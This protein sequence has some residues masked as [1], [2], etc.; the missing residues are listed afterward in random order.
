[1]EGAACER[2]GAAEGERRGGRNLHRGSGT[3]GGLSGTARPDGREVRAGWVEW[4]SG[5][6]A[7][8]DGRPWAGSEWRVGVRWASGRAGEGERLPDRVGRDRGGAEPAGRGEG[9]R[10]GVAG[11]PRRGRAAG[12]LPGVKRKSGGGGG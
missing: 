11:G 6:E 12:G 8:P 4:R 3:G 7:V 9:E 2:A 1:M 5:R 10:G